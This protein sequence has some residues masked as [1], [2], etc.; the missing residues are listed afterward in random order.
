MENKFDYFLEFDDS[1]KAKE[2]YARFGLCVYTFQVLE[3][4][5][6]NMLLIKAKS[7]KID[8][9]S[10]EYDDIF[11]SYSD[12]TMG[13]LIEKVVQLYDIPDIKR[14]ELW[15]IHQKRNYYAHHY[16]KDHS[17]H[18]FSEKKQIKMLEEII[19]TTEE[20]MF[21]DTFLE[22]LTQPIMDKMNINQEYFDYWYKQMIHG[23]DINSLK[24]TKTK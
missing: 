22:N 6:M 23:E 18:F 5:L 21:F 14:Q 2:I 10:K 13:K 24:F 3:H 11:Y 8:M 7:E 17:A 16:F 20:T 19:T 9:S 15:N 12:K 4:Q 1:E